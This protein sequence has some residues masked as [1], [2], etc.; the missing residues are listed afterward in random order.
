MADTSGLPTTLEAS[1]ASPEDALIFVID[2]KPINIEVLELLLADAGYSNVISTTRPAEALVLYEKHQPDLVLLDLLMPDLSGIDVL[3]QLKQVIPE[4]DYVPRVILTADNSDAA[5]GDALRLGAQDFI[6][7]PFDASEVILRIQNLLHTRMLQRALRA[8][9]SQLE[10]KVQARTREIELYKVQLELA[11]R[12]KYNFLATISHELRT[13]LTA[14]NGF[15]ELLLSDTA[16]PLSEQQK[17]YLADVHESG[18]HLTKLVETILELA[19]IRV[20]DMTLSLGMVDLQAALTAT[21]DVLKEQFHKRGLSFEL[22]LD[23]PLEPILADAVKVKQMIYNYLDN[24]IKFSPQG[25]L[26]TASIQDSLDEVVV[27]IQDQGTGIPQEHHQH[28]F[29]PFWQLDSSLTRQHEGTGIGLYLTKQFADLHGGR[30]WF[31]S[32]H[33]QGSTFAFVL[34]RRPPNV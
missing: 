2:D 29:E 19:D 4:D 31:D 5:K 30:V 24:A 18:K 21:V 20:N 8:S 3:R 9:N 10:A 13:P 11:N 7:K 27:Y 16:G 6:H 28:V 15:S 17:L 32:D 14:I 22:E 25:S 26:I 1:T 33:E 23:S 12:M 34:P